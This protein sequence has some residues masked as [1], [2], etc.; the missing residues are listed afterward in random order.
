M[1]WFMIIMLSLVIIPLLGITVDG[2]ND[3]HKQDCRVELSKAGKSVDEIK[4]LCK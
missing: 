4:E 1:K 2:I 3:W